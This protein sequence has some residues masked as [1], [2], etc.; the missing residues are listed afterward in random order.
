MSK[1]YLRDDHFKVI[2]SI[3]TDSSGK[4]VGRDA[5]FNRVGEYDSR[6]DKTRDSHFR[7]VGTGNQLA[8]LIWRTVK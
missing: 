4:Q 5:H 7:I 8:A 6:T 1:E 3:E 2:G